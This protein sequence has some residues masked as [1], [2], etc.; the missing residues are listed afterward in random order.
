MALKGFNAALSRGE[1]RAA[2][3]NA[4]QH[5]KSCFFAGEKLL[6][7]LEMVD[8][9][10]KLADQYKNNM[11]NSLLCIFRETIS[12]L[13]DR[14]ESTSSKPKDEITN[15]FSSVTNYR[16][17]AIQAYWLGHS[18]RCHYYV[19]KVA[20]D[21]RF[22]HLGSI[23]LTFLHGLSAFQ[24]L[25]KNNTAKLRT[26]PRSAIA[27]LKTA[28][29][30]SEWNFR[31]KVHLLEAENYSFNNKHEEAKASYAA[32]IASAHSSGFIHEEG[33][34][35]ELAGFHYK[36]IGDHENAQSLFNQ[37]KQCYA[38]WGSQVKVDSITRQLETL[39]IA[40]ATLKK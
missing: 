33:L 2:F 30:H 29:S 31:N 4:M 26:I 35:L 40:E 25:R 20:S 1:N 17:C 10:M 13:I 39:H 21:T 12:A 6:T 11:A 15:A 7:I 5:I 23:V 9:H 37:A 14:G 22:E 36:K 3:L 24:L 28:A 32:A 27:A 34:A 8:L 19:S 38:E 16:H 18:E